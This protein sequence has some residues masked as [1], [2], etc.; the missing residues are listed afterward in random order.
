VAT[1][2]LQRLGYKVYSAADGLEGLEIFK[3]NNNTID[4]VIL[5]VIMP[6]MSG[7]E[8]LKEMRAINPSVPALFITGYS[9]S[10]I[11]SSY[12]PEEGVDT[13]QKPFSFDA[14]SHRIREIVDRKNK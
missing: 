2:F 5:D 6:R 7:R 11:H 9:F 10:D 12:I 14:L 8:A 3:K 1:T 4:L 13:L